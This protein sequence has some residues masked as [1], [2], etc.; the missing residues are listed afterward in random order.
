[1]PQKPAPRRP[2]GQ[3]PRRVP[4][5]GK[6]VFR[7]RERSAPPKRAAAGEAVGDGVADGASARESSESARGGDR[8]Q[9]VL[10]AAGVA[11]R[12]ECEELITEGRVEVDGVTVTEL[13]AKV[14]RSRQTIKVDGEALPSPK[15]VYYAVNKP[16][17]VVTTARDPSGRPRVIDLLPPSVGRVFPVGRLDLESEGLIILT[18]DG[19][20]ANRLTHPQYGVEKTYDVQVAGQMEPDVLSQLK[21]GVHLSEG[22]AHAVHARIKA[23]LKRSTMLEM[24]L[25]EGRNREVRRLL[26]RVGHK[27]QRL[28]RIAVGPIR[29]GDMPRGA[30]RRLTQEEVRKL[31]E[32]AAAGRKKS[33]TEESRPRP[34]GRPPSKKP[35]GKGPVGRKPP[36]GKKPPFGTK[37]LG[38][39][40]PVIAGQEFQRKIVGDDAPAAESRSQRPAGGRKPVG[41]GRPTGKPIGAGRPT[42]KPGGGR[43]G[44][45]RSGGPRTGAG[46]PSGQ[47]RAVD[48][49]GG[50]S[51]GGGRSGGAGASG[52][53]PKFRAAKGTKTVGK[54]PVKRRRPERPQRGSNKP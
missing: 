39:R 38:A 19:E 47:G 17:G 16:T 27:V 2:S 25:D 10:A 20:L 44:G 18:N 43:P 45:A 14:D 9:K 33:E 13:G 15:L 28:T 5:G 41:V 12:R 30:H 42:G 34:A 52:G 46:K 32:A 37:P 7:D 29:L 40:K 4:R 3:P 21:R 1:M 11:S 54:K 22:Y 26:A 31:R 36:F 23:R 51:T 50:A 8:L 35:F 53:K 48:R 6:P 24:V 49:A